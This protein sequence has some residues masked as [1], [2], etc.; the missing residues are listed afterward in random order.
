METSE[1]YEK[2]TSE[3]Y[4]DFILTHENKVVFLMDEARG[5]IRCNRVETICTMVMQ[6][7]ISSSGKSYMGKKY[8][9]LLANY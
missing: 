6:L 3:E 7:I 8:K 5:M 4:K 1:I 9:K 2:I